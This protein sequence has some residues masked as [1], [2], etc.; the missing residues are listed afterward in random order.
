MTMTVTDSQLRIRRL[1][2]EYV[3]PTEHEAPEHLQQHLDDVSRKV[4][5][6]LASCLPPILDR[7]HDG[8]WL[9]R[10][11]TF[12][13]DVST[14]W[15]NDAIARRWAAA[16]AV[17]LLTEIEAGES[18]N[19]LFFPSPAALLGQFVTDLSDNAAWDKWYYRQ[20]EGLRHLTASGALR[21]ALLDEP[22]MG[23]G[24]MLGL[25][26]SALA[27]VL[28]TLSPGDARLVFDGLSRGTTPASKAECLAAT[29]AACEGLCSPADDAH[30]A[31]QLYLAVLRNQP[32]LAGG[33]LR[34]ITLGVVSLAHV[35][36]DRPGL[37]RHLR[38]QGLPALVELA[39]SHE[40]Q[41]L[42]PLL[43][44]PAE[45]IIEAIAV[46]QPV[47][48]T[49]ASDSTAAF[50]RQTAFGAAFLLAP[51]LDEPGALPY[52]GLAGDEGRLLRFLVL[53]KCL[54]A[55]QASSAWLDPVLRDLF[56]L[57]PPQG[58]DDAQALQ[59]RLARSPASPNASQTARE[60]PTFI[61]A[62]V[63][64]S[65]ARSRRL[66]LIDA[67]T[68]AWQAVLSSRD[69]RGLRATLADLPEGTRL[70]T[71]A[72]MIELVRAVGPQCIVQAI[73][74]ASG[75]EDTE[76]S[77]NVPECIN[78]LG[79]LVTDFDY[80]RLPP[81]LRGP[82]RVDMALDRAAQRVLRRLAAGLPG[83]ALS[84]L[85]YLH[86]NFLDFPAEVDADG[87]WLVQLGK[88]PL[89]LVLMMTGR[90]RTQ[91][92]PSWLPGTRLELYQ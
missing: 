4:S 78:R 84:S 5:E 47:A 46:L 74:G 69:R 87:R 76:T 21:T 14:G 45:A 29:V 26:G 10:R 13:L 82:T 49:T 62:A 60:A 90:T 38:E 81:D 92:E 41:R 12:G 19:V 15:D 30:A 33:T 6:A 31:L 43:T 2:T 80:L 3:V 51:L 9:I 20:Y 73:E 91:L 70:L 89:N 50:R 85:A 18:E 48:S 8:I 88:P 32:D 71:P 17:S 77:P 1:Q 83:F 53:I 64:A 61:L 35:L 25:N 23:L 57:S 16:V 56:G 36:A 86:R 54:G 79:D 11:L 42:L 63:P 58:T 68:G 59:S 37:A 66:V 28:R 65:R 72:A 52:D 44:L 24:A 39:G 22:E 34:E 67:N 75:T 40:A 7:A 55:P 27:N